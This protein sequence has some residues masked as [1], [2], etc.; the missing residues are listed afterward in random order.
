MTWPQVEQKQNRLQE[1]GGY[2]L[3][4]S[5]SKWWLHLVRMDDMEQNSQITQDKLGNIWAILN[6][7]DLEVV[8]SCSIYN[9]LYADIKVLRSTNFDKFKQIS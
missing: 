4:S 6:K 2:T 3:P 9:L 5:Y 7:E 8:Y 1:A